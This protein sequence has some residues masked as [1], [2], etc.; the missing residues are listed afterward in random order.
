MKKLH[1][2]KTYGTDTTAKNFLLPPPTLFLLC[3]QYCNKVYL[4]DI[5]SSN[6][7]EGFSVYMKNSTAYEYTHYTGTQAL[8]RQKSPINYMGFT[9][10]NEN[11]L[12]KRGR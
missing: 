12:N 9:K 7:N 3:Q 10:R 4:H 1:G 5:S 2:R 11:T 8:V 6:R